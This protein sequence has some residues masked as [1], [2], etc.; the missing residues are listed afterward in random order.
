MAY[1]GLSKPYYAAYS[2]S[3]TT[4]TYS[5]GGSIAKAV[6]AGITIDGKDP[7][8]LY[9][10]NGPAESGASFGGGTLTIG[11]DKLDLTVAAALLGITAPTTNT[12]PT[13]AIFGADAVAPYVGVGFVVKSLEGGSTVWRA[14]ILY[15]VQFK[16]PDFDW[17]TQGETIEFS[18]PELE[19]AILRDDTAAAK[20]GSMQDFT[21]E[22]AAEAAVKTALSIT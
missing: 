12:T 3:G 13:P 1:I 8:I 20:W 11:V 22:S 10:D 2:A 15:K 17:S 18:T 6:S 4:V 16:T 7:T 9:A 19:A 21:S 5:S 14:V